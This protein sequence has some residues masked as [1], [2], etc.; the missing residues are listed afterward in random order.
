MGFIHEFGALMS[1]G[2]TCRLTASGESY[3]QN[4]AQEA[5][6]SKIF[7]NIPTLYSLSPYFKAL[8]DT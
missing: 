1:L 5:S 8:S 6:N 7:Y 2:Q 3:I 4:W